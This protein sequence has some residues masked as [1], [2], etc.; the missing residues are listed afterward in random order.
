MSVICQET[1][2]L[3]VG[4]TSSPLFCK[5]VVVTSNTLNNLIIVLMVANLQLAIY[6]K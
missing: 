3:V 6:I 5:Q 1:L 2:P 4:N